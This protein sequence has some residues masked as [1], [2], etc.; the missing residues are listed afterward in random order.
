MLLTMSSDLYCAHR[1]GS[2]Q[3]EII[4]IIGPRKTGKTGYLFQRIPSLEEVGIKKEQILIKKLAQRHQNTKIFIRL[5]IRGHHE[6]REF[7]N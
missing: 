5:C 1:Q 3:V 6:F 2:A 7:Q 4:T